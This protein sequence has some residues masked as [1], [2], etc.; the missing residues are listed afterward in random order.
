M[1]FVLAQDCT[2]CMML[3]SQQQLWKK[4]RRKMCSKMRKMEE[5]ERSL[6]RNDA[7]NMLLK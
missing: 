7:Q 5:K 2:R 6:N 3:D 4:N 1:L